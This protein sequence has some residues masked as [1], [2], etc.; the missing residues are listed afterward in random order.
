VTE[1]HSYTDYDDPEARAP[2]PP[3]AIPL[4]VLMGEV[5]DGKGPDREESGDVACTTPVSLDQPVHDPDCDVPK[6]DLRSDDTE[7]AQSRLK[8]ESLA[9]AGSERLPTPEEGKKIQKGEEKGNRGAVR[10]LVELDEKA[11]EYLDVKAAVKPDVKALIAAF[12][13]NKADNPVMPEKATVKAMIETF[14]AKKTDD[15]AITRSPVRNLRGGMLHEVNL[16]PK[17]LLTRTHRCRERKPRERLA[18]RRSIGF[19]GCVY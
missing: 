1:Y 18:L 7:H 10:K 2:T 12:E 17:L 4:D 9:D 16:Y 13:P 14:E 19:V 5:E 8:N 3:P 6:R 11:M 15:P